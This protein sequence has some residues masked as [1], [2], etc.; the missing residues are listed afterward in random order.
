MATS[1]EMFG[2]EHKHE[3]DDEMFSSQDTDFLLV[4]G[5]V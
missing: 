4:A 5:T 2:S 3:D 1:L